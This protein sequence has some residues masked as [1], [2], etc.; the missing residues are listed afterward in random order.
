[1]TM[2]GCSFQVTV[3]APNRPCISTQARVPVA[4]QGDNGS[5]RRAAQLASV[6][7]RIRAPTVIAR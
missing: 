6:T 4:H 3:R 5:V 2:A 1:M 7:T